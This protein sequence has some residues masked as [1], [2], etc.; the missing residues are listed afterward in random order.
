LLRKYVCAKRGHRW[1]L[2]QDGVSYCP[3]C[4]TAMK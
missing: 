4:R 3:R 1:K 2:S